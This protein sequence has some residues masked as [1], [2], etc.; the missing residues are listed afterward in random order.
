MPEKQLREVA[1][2]AGVVVG[3]VSN[4]LNRP[5]LVRRSHPRRPRL[6]I[7]ELG[8]VRN[9][10]ARRLRQGQA[11]SGAVAYVVLDETANPYFTDVAEVE[12]VAPPR[13]SACKNHL[14]NSDGS[15]REGAPCLDFLARARVHGGP[16]HAGVDQDIVGLDVSCA[17]GIRVVLVDRAAGGR[18]QRRGRRRRGR[19]ARGRPPHEQ[20]TN[21]S[22]LVG[23]A[24]DHRAGRRPPAGVRPG[25]ARPSDPAD[26][27]TVLE[28]AA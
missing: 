5:E 26:A 16:D 25:A 2:A 22:R 3:T 10:S 21:A 6:A 19:R 4:V 1:T 17:W 15:C 23:G 13:V 27:V 7:D 9:E 24:D 8:I 12:E 11:A 20:G 18:L 28:T 14:A